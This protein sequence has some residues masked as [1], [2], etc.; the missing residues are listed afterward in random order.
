M[1]QKAKRRLTLHK[2]VHKKTRSLMFEIHEITNDFRARNI[3]YNFPMIARALK[4]NS[5]SR[6]DYS[7]IANV[8]NA[9]REI[10]KQV[11]K[12][13]SRVFID[14]DGKRVHEF[15]D[16]KGNVLTIQQAEK[17]FVE[18]LETHKIPY[19]YY[20][21]VAGT[22]IPMTSFVVRESINQE[23]LKKVAFA[24]ETVLEDMILTNDKIQ[25]TG[26]TAV[27]SLSYVK[28]THK[29]YLI[30][31]L[32]PKTSKKNIWEKELT[33]E[34]KAKELDKVIH[35]LEKRKM[36]LTKQILKEKVEDNN[37]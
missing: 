32:T 31:G 2:G 20:D 17:Q 1:P 37:T 4:K 27:E 26:K 33:K 24:V 8:F 30:D 12:A 19:E 13:M 9:A 35:E 3:P 25:I 21:F 10:A 14:E 15:I 16:F 7:E 36:E 34:Q 29:K 28:D 18:L 23:R 22:L 5:D 11:L 6:K